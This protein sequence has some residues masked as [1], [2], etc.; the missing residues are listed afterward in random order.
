MLD[1]GVR[2]RFREPRW[3]SEAIGAVVHP[4]N[5]NWQEFHSLLPRYE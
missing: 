5:V 1:L 4:L 3:R 2:P